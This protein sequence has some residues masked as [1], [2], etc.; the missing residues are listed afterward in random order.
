MPAYVALLRA[1]NLGAHQSIAMADLRAFAEA[2]GLKDARTLL[3]SGNLV[4]ESAKSG[5]TLESLLEKS[6]AKELGLA[7][8][9]IV[10]NAA[11]WRDIIESNP[12]PREAKDTPSRLTL[13]PLKAAP[14]AASVKA[15]QAAHKGPEKIAARGGDLYIHYVEGIGNS[16]LTNKKIEKALGALGT[17][18][19]WN[20]VLKL[21]A[22]L[23]A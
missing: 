18:R 4:F 16:K 21:E 14:S 12:F 17:V 13:M 7:T 23:G 19:N 1:V 2:L 8:P 5:A 15:L 3:Q 20:T 10:R 6:A 9:F 22:I 11:Q